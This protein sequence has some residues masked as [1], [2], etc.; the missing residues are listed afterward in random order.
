M[1]LESDKRIRV[2]KIRKT[3]LEPISSAGFFVL[4]LFFDAACSA[5]STACPKAPPHIHMAG[6]S[7]ITSR[8]Y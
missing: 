6:P 3:L 1:P 4:F 7:D 8:V 5:V 2:D